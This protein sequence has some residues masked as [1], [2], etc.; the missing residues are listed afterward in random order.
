MLGSSRP[1][2]RFA[3]GSQHTSAAL[4][5]KGRIVESESAARLEDGRITMATRTS[6]HRPPRPLRVAAERPPRIPSPSAPVVAAPSTPAELA[7][8]LSLTGRFA[9]LG[10]WSWDAR[11]DEIQV[12]EHFTA[13]IGVPRN[14]AIPMSRALEVVPQEEAEHVR[15]TLDSLASG[16]RETASID[17]R[18]RAA[19]GTERWMESHC[20]ALHDAQGSVE[21]VLGVSRDVT[22]R[23]EAAD[24]AMRTQRELESARDYMR[25]VTD[26]MDE[27]LF[28]LDARGFVTYINPSAERELGW[29]A[30]ELYGKSMHEVAHN[31]RLDG[32]TLPIEECPIMRARAQGEI[33][34]VAEDVFL[35][36]DG[37]RLPVSYTALPLS[38]GAGIE[39][40]VVIFEDITARQ[41]EQ[42]RISRDREKL[43]WAGR[44][45]EALAEGR[46]ELY[47]QPIVECSNG[48]TVQHELLLRMRDAELGIVAP[49]EFLPVAEELGLVREID[50][51]VVAESVR[52][53][54]ELG[55]VEVNLS[56]NSLGDP[57]LV[58][59][60]ERSIA[61]EG[62]DPSAIVFEIT[63]TAL[64]E[65]HGAARSFLDRL[66]RLGCK[67]ALDDFGTGYGG[68]TYLKQLPVDILKI[69]A[70][71]V[72]DLLTDEASRAVVEAIVRLARGFGLRTVAEG[73]EDARTLELVRMLGV[74][75]AQGFHLGRPAPLEPRSSP[76][77]HK[78]GREI[79]LRVAS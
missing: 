72:A 69:D 28:T 11:S 36:K 55:P 22:S 61:R 53:A 79:P 56:A 32:S 62:V 77:A 17:Y 2:E 33:A 29:S 45:Q 78:P 59:H 12:S 46:F 24:E 58:D 44:I 8:R 54:R 30:G 43:A 64:I 48:E 5:P 16:E 21:R 35:R 15:A 25:A 18:L 20:V 42:R 74:D 65:E 4:Q 26:T 75:Q 60:I 47:A 50:R 34:E 10:S 31:Q 66:H 40:C 7:A 73:V 71:F 70:E 37:T 57:H 38:A 39:G 23:V 67:I 68:F 9:D 76:R 3:A 63:E 1:T 13:L 51:W 52:V 49:G 14:E 27:S 6:T 19:D 41:A